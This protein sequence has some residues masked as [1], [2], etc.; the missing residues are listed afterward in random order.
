MFTK[1]IVSFWTCKI[2]LAVLKLLCLNVNSLYH[3]EMNMNQ[4]LKSL[5][6][7][8]GTISTTLNIVKF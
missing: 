5:L 1:E 3:Q 7:I 6:K 2:C 4:S 8:I